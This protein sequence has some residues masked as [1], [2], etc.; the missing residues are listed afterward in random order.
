MTATSLDTAA[1]DVGKIINQ[2][3]KTTVRNERLNYV[4]NCYSNNLKAG[5]LG[6][7]RSAVYLC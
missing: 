4:M 1:L 5:I 7:V 2:I 3:T 6:T